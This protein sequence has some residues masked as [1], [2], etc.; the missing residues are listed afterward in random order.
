M[1][2]LNSNRAGPSDAGHP[3]FPG[4]RGVAARALC[5]VWESDAFAA[6]LD[7]VVEAISTAVAER[8]AAGLALAGG[9]TPLALYLLVR[10]LGFRRIPNDRVGVVEK[11]WSFAG[12]VEGGHLLARSGEAGYQARLLRGGLHCLLFPWQYRVHVLPL[13]AV[14]QGKLAYVYARDG[15]PL[16]PD[17]TLFN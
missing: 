5:R 15:E 6:A 7:A 14:S 9:S 11:L 1:N 8:G 16:P 2:S 4:A 17:Q 13:V 3:P 12:S 10:L